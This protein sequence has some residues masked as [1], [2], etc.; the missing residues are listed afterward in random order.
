MERPSEQDLT[1]ATTTSA[2]FGLSVPLT[3]VPLAQH[4][5]LA[6]QWWELG[7]SDL[8]SSEGNEADA[9]TPLVV[10]ACAPTELHLGTA[11]VPVF[12]RGPAVLA[13]SAAALA[14]LAPGRVTLG[15]GTSSHL[16][17]QSWNSAT[18][19]RPYERMRD[20]LAFL[21]DAFAGKTIN[22]DYG[23]FA[24]GMYRLGLI[25]ERRPRILIA[26]L[27]ERMLRLAG[28]AADG[29]ILTWVTAA[30]VRR[31]VPHVHEG[32][33][34]HQIVAR[35]WVAPTDDTEAAHRIGRR[36]SALFL[37]SPALRAAHEWLGRGPLLA[38]S[39][40]RWDEGDLKGSAAAVPVELLDEL[41]V[42]GSPADVHRRVEEYRSAGVDVPVLALLPVKGVDL[43]QAARDLAPGRRVT[44]G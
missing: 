25:P 22:E 35:I 7:Y 28:S 40:R 36:L 20:T 29:A 21:A 26:A 2:R 11:I 44:T 24:V 27:R 13:Q 30:D 41:V 37:N 18:F 33:D 34:G 15:L 10:A 42:H 38:E 17:A 16:I 5:A 19:E 1:A 14:E 8:W 23:T 3:G 31:M 12:G 43:L 32:G 39:W 4:G 6:R 9:F